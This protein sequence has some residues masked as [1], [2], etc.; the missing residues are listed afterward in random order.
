[1]K[2]Q[3]Y[4]FPFDKLPN[5]GELPV[6]I[7]QAAVNEATAVNQTP[8][9]MGHY[10]ALGAASTAAQCLVDIEK[11]AGGIVSPGNYIMI[12]GKS[13]ERKTRLDGIFCKPI[14]SFQFSLC[15]PSE[16]NELKREKWKVQKDVLMGKFKKAVKND[17]GLEK[18]EEDLNKH[19]AEEPKE[20][21][22]IYDD[23]TI[24]GLMAGLKEFP[25]AVILSSDSEKLF[26]RVILANGSEF[27]KIW[28]SELLSVKR[29]VAASFMLEDV[30]LTI[31]ISIQTDALKV[32]MAGDGQGG[33]RN[34]LTARFVICDV[35]EESTQGTRFIGIPVLPRGHVE[36]FQLRLNEL[37]IR[38]LE[39]S[40]DPQFVRQKLRFS[41]EAAAVWNMYFNYTEEQQQAGGRY[42]MHSG[43]ASKLADVA[44]R[45]AGDLHLIESDDDEISISSLLSAIRLC[46]ESSKDYVKIIARDM[47]E[48]EAM[49][50]Y[51]WMISRQRET[52]AGGR[53]S[54][55]MDITYIRQYT[56]Y[57]MRSIRIVEKY[58][59]ILQSKKL[60]RYYPRGASKSTGYVDLRA[61]D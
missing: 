47:D 6:A 15:G 7:F 22:I 2:V 48:D 11:P 35:S 5:L 31:S 8:L 51:D 46:D 50:L 37:L 27:N 34:G 45:I 21:N 30:R 10:C 29:K 41:S 28:S 13:G 24:E 43:H 44:A 42:E 18:L 38:Y 58:L 49:A 56:L 61:W 52:H 32:I 4:P 33:I 12:V 3:K 26:K 40:K 25:N 20:K 14:M 1:M 9:K 16:S 59:F 23:T 36:K 60:L 39:L 17:N 55:F 19:N 53:V 54:A 57:R